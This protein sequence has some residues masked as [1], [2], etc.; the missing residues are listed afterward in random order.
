MDTQLATE[1]FFDLRY[2]GGRSGGSV[3]PPDP[4][5]NVHPFLG[6]YL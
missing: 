6:H 1:V 3:S 5:W 2:F 4:D